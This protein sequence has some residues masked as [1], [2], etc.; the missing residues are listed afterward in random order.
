MAQSTT[1]W[2]TPIARWCSWDGR[3]MAAAGLK[4]ELGFIDPLLRRR[5]SPL[6]R[7]V[8]HVAAKCVPQDS[9][10]VQAVRFV[11][12]SR[13]GEL[14]RTL[15]LLRDLANDNPLSP[16]NF[17]LSVLNATPGLYSIARGDTSS[18][19]AVAAGTETLGFGLLEAHARITVDPCGPVLFVYADAPAPV[20]LGP[21][22]EDPEDVLAIG[23]L[24]DTAGKG[25][26]A[27]SYTD[28]YFDN[29]DNAS[30]AMA[31]L[32]CL[33]GTGQGLWSSVRR[34]WQWR[35]TCPVL[36]AGSAMPG[37]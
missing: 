18:A 26:L 37:A 19:T 8:L 10:D 12:A 6:A 3:K 17:S 33:S 20:P 14:D 15:E 13:H 1:S 27:C 28:I 9:E 22:P 4:P 34:S 29:D 35:L 21:L 11:Y 23:V 2:Q 31:F 30:Q 32:S 16:T 24:L 25:M 5:L 36:V 7:A